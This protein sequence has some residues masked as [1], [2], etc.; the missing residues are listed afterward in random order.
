MHPTGTESEFE[1]VLKAEDGELFSFFR[2]E[3]RL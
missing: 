2:F 3:K 1:K